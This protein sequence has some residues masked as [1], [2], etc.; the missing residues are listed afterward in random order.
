MPST[1][2][3]YQG[4][5]RRRLYLVRHG[6]VN[7]FD[8]AG[9]PLDPRSVPLSADGEAQV[10]ALNSILQGVTFDRAISSDYPRAI[11]TL[12]MV[13]SGRSDSC[14]TESTAALREIR[15]GRLSQMP[16]ESY[17]A[18]VAEAYHWSQKPGAGFLRGERWDDFGARV[19]EW[20][21][22]L[23]EDPNWQSAVIASHDAVNRVL[24]SWLMSGDL[25]SL[26]FLEQDHACLN[27]VDVDRPNADGS[28]KAYLRL[29][30][31]TPYNPVKSGE[32]S[33]VMERIAQSMLSM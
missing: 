4:S 29:L 8:A 9:H 32:R 26:P 13:L 33:T 10:Q 23:L 31:H 15:A 1:P 18:E 12:E 6:H 7:Y 20:F 17:D 2:N 21:G 25:S 3:R 11:Q 16:P 19:L 24:I 27:I 14:A 5:G 28:A 22:T 30:N